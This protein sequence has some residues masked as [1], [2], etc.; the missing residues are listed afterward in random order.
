MSSAF[1]S[2]FAQ[3]IAC[4]LDK[5]PSS[6]LIERR[7]FAEAIDDCSEGAY[8]SDNLTLAT[9]QLAGIFRGISA[10]GDVHSEKGETQR[11]STS[12]QAQSC[13][14]VI[15][16]EDDLAHPD[17]ALICGDS[18][19]EWVD[20]I[21]LDSAAPRIRWMHAKVQKIESEEAN[22]A[23]KKKTALPPDVSPTVEVR[24]SPLLSASDLDDAARRR[25]DEVA[26]HVKARCAMCNAVGR[27]QR[28]AR[29]P[30]RVKT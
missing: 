18:T 29:A 16:T 7:A 30:R 14:H 6:V 11:L 3:P 25:A 27:K 24:K 13:F 19:V 20:C 23:K 21:E 22:E 8:G 12:F 26:R 4:L 15:E 10:L 9:R 28:A 17:S 1:L 5:T 2:Q